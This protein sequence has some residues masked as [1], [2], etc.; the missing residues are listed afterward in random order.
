MSS[1]RPLP[2]L[3]VACVAVLALSA[4]RS[5][6]LGASGDTCGRTDDCEAPLRCV[7]A[8]CRDVV[9][10]AGARPLPR[11]ADVPRPRGALPPLNAG[12]PAETPAPADTAP[13][14]LGGRLATQPPDETSVPPA[15]LPGQH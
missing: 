12:T 6:R 2:R 3:A 11:T 8:V 5:P 7:D 10:G 9:A 1:N 15:G 14:G 13:A 4:C